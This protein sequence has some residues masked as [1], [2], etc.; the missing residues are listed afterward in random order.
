MRAD[1]PDELLDQI[2]SSARQITLEALRANSAVITW[3]S[4][5]GMTR[6]GNLFKRVFGAMTVLRWSLPLYD[7]GRLQECLVMKSEVFNPNSLRFRQEAHL[8][9]RLF[10]LYPNG[11]TVLLLNSQWVGNPLIPCLVD[12][13]IAHQSMAEGCSRLQASSMISS[14]RP[15]VGN[16]DIPTFVVSAS[17]QNWDQILGPINKDGFAAQWQVFS[18]IT[19]NRYYSRI[20]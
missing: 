5:S 17:S 20:V 9:N 15:G 7:F 10:L 18:K 11:S 2:L 13:Q 8:T 14:H 4:S 12:P 6:N 3:H 1:A 19:N 16:V